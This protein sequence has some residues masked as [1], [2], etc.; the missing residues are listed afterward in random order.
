[1]CVLSLL[2]E[3]KLA[4]ALDKFELC[5]AELEQQKRIIQVQKEMLD[6]AEEAC[7]QQQV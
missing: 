7:R 6:Q 2:T 4:Q 3:A 1:V 5:Q